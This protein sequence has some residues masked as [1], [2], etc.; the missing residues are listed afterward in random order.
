MMY[1]NV[2]S[3]LDFHIFYNNLDNLINNEFGLKLL[4]DNSN[5]EFENLFESL[6]RFW[7]RPEISP[8]TQIWQM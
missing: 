3:M 6:S 1:Y 8:F 5:P 2:V 4:L 7:K